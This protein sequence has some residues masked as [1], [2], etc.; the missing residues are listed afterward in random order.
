MFLSGVLTK[1]IQK[2]LNS[3]F[4]K[5]ADKDYNI[6]AVTKGALTQARAKLKPEAFIE[7]SQVAIR[8]FYDHENYRKWK[9]FR[10]LAIDGSTS[11][12]PSHPSVKKEFATILTGCKSSVE[13]SIARISLFYDVLNCT[14]LDAQIVSQGISENS[15]LQTHLASGNLKPGDI[16]LADRG[17]PSNA[18]M[19]ELHQKGVDFCMRMR[20]HWNEV[21][22]FVASNEESRIVR[23]SLLRKDKQLQKNYSPNLPYVECRLVAIQLASG[24]KEVLCTSL[25][26]ETKYTIADMRALYHFRW[27]IEEA[28]K[29]LKVRMQLSNYSGKT[30][31]SVKQDF[32]A[33]IFMMNMCA[34]MS[35]PIEEKVRK[36]NQASKTKH[37]QQLNKTSVIATLKESW[38]ALWLKKKT[39]QI[40]IAF[41]EILLKTKEIVRPHRKFLRKK[42]RYPDRK[43][44]PPYK[45]I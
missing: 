42:Y 39:K 19:Y 45:S 10:L 1:S 36:E 17:Y 28:Y 29:L 14:T 43:P 18:L 41:D 3:F 25:L 31:N 37:N 15:L 2:E 16:L 32:F 33:K 11:N 24:E 21:N 5:L 22:D 6:L 8:D 4:S 27:N 30:S 26:D 35:F 13:V 12:L 20:S 7:L 44:S 9:G 38:L 23:F 34:I 40:L